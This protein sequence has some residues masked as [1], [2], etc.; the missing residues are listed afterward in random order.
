L[1]QVPFDVELRGLIPFYE[2]TVE[3]VIGGIIGPLENQ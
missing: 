2:Q 1:P 3:T